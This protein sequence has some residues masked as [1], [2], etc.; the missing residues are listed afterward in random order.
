[1]SVRVCS[2][3]G[4]C[5]PFDLKLSFTVDL[6]IGLMY[7]LNYEMQVSLQVY[8]VC[9]FNLVLCI[10]PK[11]SLE[12]MPDNVVLLIMKLLRGNVR[13]LVM[14]SRVCRRFHHL[15]YEDSIKSDIELTKESIGTKL[16]CRKLRKIITSYLPS[17]VWR[18]KLTSNA[19]THSSKN[20]IVNASVINDLF[21][22]CPKIKS[23]ILENCDL[24]SVSYSVH[25]DI[26]LIYL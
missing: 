9:V 11:A 8:V 18:V 3:R 19:N 13:S 6:A 24:S 22:K 5:R 16:D 14:M 7:D 20:P 12:G 10:A 2:M 26:V 4:H 1:M 21:T 15:H 17:T 23:I 25:V